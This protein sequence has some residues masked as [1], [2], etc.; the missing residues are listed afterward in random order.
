MLESLLREKGLEALGEAEGGLFE[1]AI[2][3]FGNGEGDGKTG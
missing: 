2:E 3:E 1:E